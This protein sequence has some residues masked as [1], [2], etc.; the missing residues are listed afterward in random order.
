MQTD[1]LNKNKIRKEIGIL[2]G[3]LILHTLFHLS[4]F[5]NIF[6]DLNIVDLGILNSAV[7]WTL[8]ASYLIIDFV[9]IWYNWK[10][11]PIHRKAKID[12]TWLILMMGLIGLWLWIPNKKQIEAYGEE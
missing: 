3:F 6:F 2:R 1:T 11:L 12:N 10:K 7:L 4:L 8:S 5:V 9:F